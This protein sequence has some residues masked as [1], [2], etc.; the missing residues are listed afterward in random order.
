MRRQ[1]IVISAILLSTVLS[2]CA[3]NL[4]RPTAAADYGKPP[5]NYE[6]IVKTH[7]EA[8]LKDPESARYK[9]SNPVKAY[10]NEGIA[11]GGGIRWMGY[12]VKVEVNAKNSFGGYVGY[13]PYLILFSGN[14]IYKEVSGDSHPLIHSVD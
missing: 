2:G 1:L 13:K 7:F 4:A 8:Q 11:Y 6:A 9:F 14:S 10:G 12:L 5:E 3:S